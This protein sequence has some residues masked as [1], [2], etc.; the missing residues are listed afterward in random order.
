MFYL[1]NA[2]FFIYFLN[3]CH[4]ALKYIIQYIILIDSVVYDYVSLYQVRYNY[5]VIVQCLIHNPVNIEVQY[6]LLLTGCML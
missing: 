1:T 6:I 3:R 2:R 5:D 4:H